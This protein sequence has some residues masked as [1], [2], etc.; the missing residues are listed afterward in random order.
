MIIIFIVILLYP[1]V[2][3]TTLLVLNDKCL[4]PGTKNY[5]C[6]QLE[7]QSQLETEKQRAATVQA[8]YRAQENTLLD[9]IQN[10]PKRI[11]AS[12]G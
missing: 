11:E 5:R 12:H 10:Q 1:L 6:R 8:R 3:G 4:L 7:R 2:V 9:E